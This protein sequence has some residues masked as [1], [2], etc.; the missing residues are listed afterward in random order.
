MERYTISL[1]EPLAREFDDL[2]RRRGYAN[3]SE[4]VRDM[5]RRELE[6]DRLARDEAPHCVA[7]LSYI[8]DHHERQLSER[9]T[10]MQHHAHD[11]VVSSMHVHLDHEHCLETL[12]LRGDTGETR[13]FADQLAAERGVRHAQ[14]NLVPVDIEAAGKHTHSRPKT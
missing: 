14:L 5:L 3:R 9:L 4:A 6:A 12:I 1:D 10:D 7:A 2:I 11:L 8:Y 13:H